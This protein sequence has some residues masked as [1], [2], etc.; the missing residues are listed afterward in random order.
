MDLV[1]S[2][3]EY[4]PSASI[5]EARTV[6]FATFAG[7]AIVCPSVASSHASAEANVLVVVPPPLES[8]TVIE[9]RRGLAIHD[10]GCVNLRVSVP[11]SGV[12]H[13]RLGP[14]TRT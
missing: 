4:L 3:W 8:V 13:E 11:A 9:A 7:T 12:V 10:A 1:S 5:T 2:V 6:Y 14:R